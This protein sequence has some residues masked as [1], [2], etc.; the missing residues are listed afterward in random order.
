[1]RQLGLERRGRRGGRSVRARQ[2]RSPPVLR[3]LGNGAYTVTSCRTLARRSVAGSRRSALIRITAT[4]TSLSHLLVFGS[5]NI[6]SLSQSKLDDLLTE[7]RDRSVDVI[8]LCYYVR[9]GMMPILC[10]L[11]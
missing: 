6:R 8:M 10:L 5:I 7:M 2:Q 9:H 4:L 3:R 11:A 1:M